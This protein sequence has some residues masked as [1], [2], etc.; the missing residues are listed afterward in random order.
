MTPVSRSPAMSARSTG[1][2]PRQRGSS[3]GWTFSQS[4]LVEQRLGDQQRRRRRRRPCPR[5][6]RTRRR[7]PAGAP[8]IPSRSAASFAGGAREPAPAAAR[9]V[10]PRQQERDL[11]PRRE[12]LEH[13]RA[14][15]RG[16]GDAD[17]RHRPERA[18]GCGRRIASASRRASA[19]VRS[20]ISIAVEVVELVLGDARRQPLEL[21]PHV[22][23]RRVLPLERH[24][25]VP[26]DR[27]RATPWSERQPSSSVSS[28]SLGSTSAG[29]TSATGVL[30]RPAGRRK[31]AGGRR[32]ASRRARRRGV[33]HQL[34]IRSTSRWRSLV[35]VLDLVGAHR[36]DRDRRYWRICASAS[37]ARCALALSAV[38]LLV[39]SSRPG[40]RARRS[41]S[42][43]SHHARQSSRRASEA[44]RVD[45]DDGGQAGAAHRRR[46]GGEQR[47]R[48]R[49][50][51]APRPVRLRD[52]LRAV[53][54][55]RRSSGAGPSRS[56]SPRAR[57][58][59]PA[60]SLQ[61]RVR[62]R[63]PATTIAHE[64]A[65]RRIAELAPALELAGEEAARR[66][67]A[68]R[69]RSRARR[70]G[71]SGRAPGRARRGR[72]APR[73]ASA[74]WNV[75][76]SARKSG[77]AE[78]RVGVDDRGE[79]DAGEVVALRD[80]LRAEQHGA[81]G[82]ARS[83]R[84]A[85]ASS[86]GCSTVSASRRITLELGDARRQLA[87]EPLRACADARELGGAARRAQLAARARRA[88]QWWQRS[89]PSPCRTSATSQFGQRQR[90]PARAAVERGRDAAAVEEQ[91]RLA[92]ALGDPAELREQR[93]RERIAAPRGA[94]RR[95]A[96]A[97]ACAAMRPPSSSRS[98]A[99]QLSGRG[100]A[101][102]K[103]AT[104]PSSAARFAATVR[105][106]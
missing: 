48:P 18:T 99:A 81:V 93:R 86:A 58:A 27:H 80:H 31:R 65:E 12:P 83:A 21:E 45:V 97:A 26:L 98:S 28:S 92:A 87:L 63:R 9:R 59:A 10:R 66:R 56:S 104:A 77:S 62:L 11:V 16:R 41:R 3:D 34:L 85:A 36:S 82:G 95:R 7:A 91:D 13:V 57:R 89:D 24:A 78:A 22:A 2:A 53:R 106:S 1:A 5:R 79:R 4:A 17:P 39:S 46:R 49:A 64:V 47:A 73:A 102:P 90:R 70:A 52:E 54:P 37:A 96:P 55:R 101:L 29:L 61:R 60:S 35:E 32:P 25:L 43:S 23:R 88:P 75:R 8:R 42:W 71:T 19:V 84:S 74:S 100:V 20:R 30:L 94:G 44:L 38:E 15:R 6:D 68:P 40:L 103:T 76:S 69:A 72:C 51:S 105:A 33:V 67:A 14:E 50:A